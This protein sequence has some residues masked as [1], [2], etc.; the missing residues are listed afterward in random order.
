MADDALHDSE[1]PRAALAY[2]A[3]QATGLAGAVNIDAVRAMQK[4]DHGDEGRSKT[5]RAYRH[6]CLEHRLFLCPLNDLGPHVAAATDNL[7]LPPLTEKFSERPDGHLPPP[8][9]GFFSQ[10]K[11]EYASARFTLFEGIRRP[12]PVRSPATMLRA[13]P[14]AG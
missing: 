1:D 10:M 9:V 3:N 2:F 14:G 7:M 5:E 11:Q 4:L 6:W 12:P 8:I 13:Q